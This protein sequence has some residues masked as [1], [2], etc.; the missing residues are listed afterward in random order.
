[1]TADRIF[2][3]ILFFIFGLIGW[4]V[5]TLIAGTNDLTL[6]TLKWAVPGA[7]I[8]AVIGAIVAPYLTTKPARSVRRTIRQL[9]VQQ[10]AYG[11]VGLII[12][13]IIA[14]LLALPLSKLPAPFG[15]VLPAI[16]AVVF[17]YLGITVMV[18][19]ADDITNM[20]GGRFQSKS[21]ADKEEPKP[22]AEP[23]SVLLDSSVIIDG[24][25]ADISQTG[26]ITGPMLIPRFVLNEVQYIADSSDSLRRNRGRR[27]LDMLGKLQRDSVVPVIITDMDVKNVRQV[28]DKLVQ[29]AKQLNCPVITNDFNLNQVAQLQGVR[30]L[31]INALANA[32]KVLV[33]P[34]ESI[35]VRVIDEGKEY[36]QGVG[37]LDDGTMV[38]VE[39]GHRYIDKEIDVQVTKV[40]QTS[41]G[42][43]IFG[44]P[45]NN[46]N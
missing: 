27:G 32:V 3:V 24:R 43:M 36:G 12:G 31:N 33:L 23:Q 2:R 5:G 19:R 11:G 38:V 14:A 15:N 35:R 8:F 30:V 26:F 25:I 18:L 39:N 6:N 17:G 20:L 1:M 21:T 37:Y 44:M 10:L 28:D 4:Y 40:L 46:S 45:T 22:E 13:L 41:A 7:L 9:P 42:R 16:G 34:G 29:L